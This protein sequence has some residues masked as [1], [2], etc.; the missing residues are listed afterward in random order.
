MG[1]SSGT[2]ADHRPSDAVDRTVTVGVDG[3]EASLTA[4]DWAAD[5]AALRGAALRIVHAG[6]WEP[7]A[8]TAEEGTAVVAAAERRA[9]HRQPG[10]KVGI[11]LILEAPEYALVRESRNA[12]V[13]V[14]GCRG[15]G[16][17]AEALL[18]SVSAMVARHTHCPVIVVRGPHGHGPH[19]RGTPVSGP[20]VEPPSPGRVV[21]GVGEYPEGSA[22]VRFAVEEA[23]LWGVP[24]EAV[25]A[26]RRPRHTP[27]AHPLLAGAPA[28]AHEQEA[29]ETLE[30]ALRGAPENLWIRRRTVEGPARDT[31]LAAA[32]DAALLVV[33]GHGGDDH[34]GRITHGVLHHARCPVAVV[35]E[36]GRT[37][38]GPDRPAPPVHSASEK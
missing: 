14:L 13:M 8:D 16:A 18:G 28:H 37:T 34:L 1:T 7:H 3:S 21:V 24:L 38:R 36:P 6:W 5:E 10:V 26:W 29:V 9:R 4:L 22:A 19:G 33:G 20:H 25:R 30:A 17:V 31:L 12:L 32:R 15:R 23:L 35:P 2:A 11:G 27:A